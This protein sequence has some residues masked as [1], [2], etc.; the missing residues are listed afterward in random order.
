MTNVEAVVQ[1]QK[2]SPIAVTN[3]QMLSMPLFSDSIVVFG[4]LLRIIMRCTL[5][6]YFTSSQ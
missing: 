5:Y 2:N 4:T 1:Y 3:P 6:D